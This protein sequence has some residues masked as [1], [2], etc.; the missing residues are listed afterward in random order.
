MLLHS[1]RVSSSILSTGCC[2]CGMFSVCTRGF[3]PGNMVSSTT[4]HMRGGELAY[5]WVHGPLTSCSR[6][7]P[8]MNSEPTASVIELKHLL[9]MNKWMNGWI[10]FIY[11]YIYFETSNRFRSMC[12]TFPLK[13]LDRML[14]NFE[15]QQL[16]D[17]DV[18]MSITDGH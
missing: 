17:D 13:Y 9:K 15:F 10:T 16:P 5:V 14:G 3:P 8:G 6:C 1:S 11:I 4:K 7:G 12:E 2:L 18:I